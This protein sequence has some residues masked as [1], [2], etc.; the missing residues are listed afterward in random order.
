LRARPASAQRPA[1]LW[2]S[3]SVHGVRFS[4]VGPG[5]CLAAV[6]L[7]CAACGPANVRV[8]FGWMRLPNSAGAPGGPWI[9]APIVDFVVMLQSPSPSQIEALRPVPRNAMAIADVAC[10]PSA[11][12]LK[13]CEVVRQNPADAR[14]RRA[15]LQLASTIRT[16]QIVQR[17]SNAAEARM[18]ASLRYLV[19]FSWN[20]APEPP[21]MDFPAVQRT[22]STSAAG[23]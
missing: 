21:R 3:R 7:V 18:D 15:A 9:E 8:V 14:V 13:D 12:G 23:A 10:R 20:R 22:A 6:S 5:T 2:G 16:E 11:S 17:H 1:R 4:R 19:R